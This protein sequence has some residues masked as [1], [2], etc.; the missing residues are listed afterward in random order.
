MKI[1]LPYTRIVTLGSLM[2]ATAPLMASD[3]DDRIESATRK[4]YVF[5]KYLKDDSIK[6]ESE[7]GV[8]TLTGSVRE[9]SHKTLARETVAN[10]PGVK[11]VKDRLEVE[12]KT[13]AEHSDAWVA[14]K[15][16][17][18]LLFHRNVRATKTDVK[19]RDGVVTLN[20]EASSMAQKDL[21]TEYAK[22]IE[23]VKEVVNETTV[24]PATPDPAP[25]ELIDDASIIAQVKLTL[26][27][28][29]STS[30]IRPTVAAQDGVVTVGG[31]A[32]NAAE[33]SLVTKLIG[34]INGV[35]D[36]VNN[37]VVNGIV[38]KN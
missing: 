16:K 25:V 18:T 5:K 30:A 19:V 17:S 13:T 23:G 11:E 21:T 32:K 33:K 3:T 20:G 37:M 38:S 7:N 15:V 36:V 27:S 14:L 35:K 6:T 8:V 10:L 28:H 24:I 26:A 1:T 4:S 31:T 9:E 2:L 29:R 34:D 22:D 12:E